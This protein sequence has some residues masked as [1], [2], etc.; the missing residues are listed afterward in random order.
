MAPNDMLT[1]CSRGII[2]DVGFFSG[3]D[4]TWWTIVN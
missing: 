2:D 4:D 3:D 1:T